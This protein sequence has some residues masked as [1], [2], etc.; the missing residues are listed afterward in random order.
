MLRHFLN[1]IEERTGIESAVKR[2]F[3]EDIPDSSG[4]HQVFGSIALF[5]FLTQMVTGILLALNYAPTPGEA[6]ESL[7]YIMTQVTAGRLVR[8]LHHWGASLMI[9]VVVLHMI[10]AFVWGTYKKPRE[11]TWIAGVV[12]F[13]VTLAYGLSGYLLPWD[14]RAYWGTV[15]TTQ[16]SALAPGLGLYLLKLIGSDGNA[17]G[18]VTFARFY[19]AH[20]LLLPPLTMLLI[21]LHLYLVRRHGITPLPADEQKPKKKFYPEQVA[22]D[23]VAIF[24][25]FAILMGMAF[26]ARVPLGHMADPT[27]LSYVPRPE[28]Y[29]LFL[30]QLLKWFEGPLEVVGAVIIPT[31]A[32]FA[33]VLVPFVDR[34]KMSRIRS[35]TSAI[36]V[37][38]LVAFAWGG[39]TARAVMT[40][41]E[42]REMDMASMEP[43]QEVSAGNLAAIGFY[44]RANCAR[45]HISGKA[46][47]ALDLTEA[48]STR[49]ENW[50]TKHI[51]QPA[52]NGTKTGLSDVQ[53][54]MLVTY[55]TKRSEAAVDALQ[56]TPQ[57][58]IDG[59]TLYI[60]NN[61]QGCHKIN[62]VGDELGPPLNGVG[63]RQTKRWIEDHFTDPPKYSPDS[64][65]PP[66]HFTKPD[67]ELITNYITSIPK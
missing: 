46:G 58:A 12:L 45:C 36:A 64:I 19:T 60:D 34:A 3:Y 59:A 17:I 15:V 7:R 54:Q 52:P 18:A 5:A 37:V 30:F 1:W 56:N 35:R 14:N 39:L 16:I 2:F 62:G 67:L 6:Y 63:E 65:M 13:L 10:Q 22:K 57:R 41:P 44:R 43:W 23:T 61:C 4:W 55:V 51:E 47:P 31:L 53:V 9:I 38:V 8:G 28:W 27:D 40:T 33:L 48:P 25:W 26:F 49:P 29:F 11:A 50:L 20:V 42:M 66:Y 21:A 32:V 24:G